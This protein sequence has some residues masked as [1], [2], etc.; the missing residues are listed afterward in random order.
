MRVIGSPASSAG[1]RQFW[2]GGDFI[3]NDEPQGNQV[4]GPI[5]KR[6]RSSTMR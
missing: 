2:L 5:K 4:F 3:K 1:L 6:F